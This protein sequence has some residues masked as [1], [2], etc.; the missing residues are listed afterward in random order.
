MIRVIPNKCYCEKCKINESHENLSSNESDFSKYLRTNTPMI[1]AFMTTDIPDAI[2]VG[3]TNQGVKNRVAQW[4]QKYNNITELGQWT[5]S[6][7][8]QIGERV[9]FMDHP[10][11]AKI[12][13]CG[14]AN[15]KPTDTRFSSIENI[16]VSKEFFNKYKGIDKDEADVLSEQIIGDIIDELKNDIHNNTAKINLYKFI[17]KTTIQ[18]AGKVMGN[19]NDFNPMPLQQQCIDNAKQ[20]VEDGKTDLLMAAVMRFGKT[21]ATYWIIKECNFKYVVVTSAKADTRTAWRNDINHM[22]FIDDFCFIEF[23]GKYNLLVSEKDDAS[24]RI[25]TESYQDE[26]LIKNKIK[27]GK[28]VVI[29]ATLQ[30]LSGKHEA[31][32]S[33]LGIENAVPLR[34]IKNKHRYIFDNQPD[35]LVIDETHYGSHSGVYGKSTGLDNVDDYMDNSDVKT[36]IKKESKEIGKMDKYTKNINARYRLQC[37]GT[38]YYILA[39]GEFAEKYAQKTIISDVSQ[40]D[41]IESRDRWIEE[42]PDKDESESPYF[43][44][45]NVYKF[46]MRLTKE[47]NRA[48][49]KSN[50]S[51]SMHV[52]FKNDGKK[53][54]HKKAVKSLMESIFGANNKD[55]P[56]W[57][58]EKKIKNGEIFKHMVMVLPHIDDCHLMKKMLIDENIVNEKERES[59]LQ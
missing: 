15:L 38:P 25:V 13:N 45:P 55:M 58:N 44:I 20:A 23:D 34:K 14:Y 48:L 30:D 36:E 26:D 12:E 19:P 31:V 18:N 24:G 52:L 37:S 8:N 22:D 51:A 56:G 43:G 3:Y 21:A 46:G 2:K 47:C 39:S 1:Y 17:N 9:F 27:S 7:F 6:E 5:A 41:M 28:T 35:M 42:N 10:V 4:T 11:H 33:T 29:Y 54:A 32:S 53:F 16:H 59:L 50:E 57:L 40:S 49:A